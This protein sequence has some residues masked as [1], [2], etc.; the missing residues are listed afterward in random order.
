MSYSTLHLVPA[1]GAT[2]GG[3]TEHKTYRNSHR[4]AAMWWRT[5]AEYYRPGSDGKLNASSFD[6]FRDCFIALTGGGMDRVWRLASNKKVDP[7]HR[8]MIQL[9]F[10]N[11]MVER[12]YMGD[13]ADILARFVEDFGTINTG[14]AKKIEKDIRDILD[15]VIRDRY[16]GVCFTWTSV[17]DV[18]MREDITEV[19]EEG[20]KLWRAYDLSKDPPPMWM[21]QS[22][23]D[24]GLWNPTLLLEGQE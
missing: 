19:D 14:H 1:V 17:A 12:N 13:L 4:S 24:A 20:E 11:C 2:V 21:F 3:I 22:M 10:D 23:T 6:Y 18:W 16:T 8:A 15:H 9:T 7:A 5:I